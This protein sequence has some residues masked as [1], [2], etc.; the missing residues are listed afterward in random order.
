MKLNNEIIVERL[1][2]GGAALLDPEKEVI[3]LIN[4]TGFQILT[5]SIGHTRTEAQERFFNLVAH[6][7]EDEDI[8]VYK[9]YLDQL[10]DNCILLEE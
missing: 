7:F 4:N 9:E 8:D 3:F 1:E 5:S 2:N 10:I 6:D